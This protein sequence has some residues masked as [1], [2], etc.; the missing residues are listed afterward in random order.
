LQVLYISED[1]FW[2]A[3]LAYCCCSKAYKRICSTKE[4]KTI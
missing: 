4:P 2:E 3:K 1:P